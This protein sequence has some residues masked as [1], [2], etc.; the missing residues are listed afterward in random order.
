[1]RYILFVL[2]LFGAYTTVCHTKK[3]NNLYEVQNGLETASRRYH[4]VKEC[5]GF[6]R[7][8]MDGQ[9]VGGLEEEYN[10]WP[11]DGSMDLEYCKT[12]YKRMYV[13]QPNGHYFSVDLYPNEVVKID[14]YSVHTRYTLYKKWNLV[15]YVLS[16]DCKNDT[17]VLRD[18]NL[19][20][21]GRA[22]RYDSNNFPHWS[23]QVKT[24]NPPFDNYE[25]NFIMTSLL[26]AENSDVDKECTSEHTLLGIMFFGGI[27]V[28]VMFVT[29]RI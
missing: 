12:G 26:V 18:V 2:L 28:C 17:L 22:D 7:L 4:F 13:K 5:T 8:Y 11:I 29:S 15:G 27:A 19:K 1:M 9:K 20:S 23:L 21:I 24:S 6:I 14:G 3:S 10:I 25:D 16:D